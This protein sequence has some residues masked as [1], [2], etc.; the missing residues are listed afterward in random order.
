V[1]VTR[2][3]LDVVLESGKLISP[4]AADIIHPST[5]RLEAFRLQAVQP[6]AGVVLELVVGNEAAGLEHAQVTAERR[7]THSECL[8]QLAGT[9]WAPA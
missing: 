2:P 4:Q 1:P 5:E 8:R 6:H 9:V 3:P 7:R